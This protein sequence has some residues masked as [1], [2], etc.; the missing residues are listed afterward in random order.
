[1]NIFFLVIRKIFSG[2]NYY[3]G[4]YDMNTDSSKK[5]KHENSNSE[6]GWYW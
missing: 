5:K 1:M 6:K 3:F 2:I 4:F